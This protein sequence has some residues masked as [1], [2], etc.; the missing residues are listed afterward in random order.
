MQLVKLGG[1]EKYGSDDNVV[2]PRYVVMIKYTFA[3]S[4]LASALT[5]Q[6]TIFCFQIPVRRIHKR[7]VDAG[8]IEP[9]CVLKVIFARVHNV[10][11]VENE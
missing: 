8:V 9:N 11:V 2:R 4:V 6:L 7:C 3:L 1:E 10:V 5:T